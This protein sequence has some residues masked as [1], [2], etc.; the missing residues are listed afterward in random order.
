MP[1]RKVINDENLNNFQVP[2]I[3]TISN[4]DKFEADFEMVLKRVGGVEGITIRDIK[5]KGFDDEGIDYSMEALKSLRR[6]IITEKR[7]EFIHFYTIH[8]DI[9]NSYYNNA[10]GQILFI[11]KELK[12]IALMKN[13]PGKFDALLSLTLSLD[14]KAEKW[15]NRNNIDELSDC[16][17]LLSSLWKDTILIHS[18]EELKIDAEYTRPGVEYLLEK[19]AET[20][21]AVEWV[22]VSFTYK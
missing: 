12:K 14:S 8:S 4:Y 15:L 9:V 10:Y 7:E 2:V 19:F 18:N 5:D 13:L 21:N 22:T 1:K 20:I 16:I 3:P 17:L 6:L 11:P